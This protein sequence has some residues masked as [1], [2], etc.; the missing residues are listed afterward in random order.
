V[1]R[2]HVAA[3]AMQIAKRDRLRWTSILASRGDFVVAN[4][5]VFG[6]GLN[7]FVLNALVAI[8]RRQFVCTR[9]LE[10]C[11]G[12]GVIEEVKATYFVWT[13]VTAISSTDTAVVDHVV[14]SFM[15]VN[16]RSDRTNRFA[17]SILTVMTGHRL[18][19]DHLVIVLSRLF[20]VQ[21][22]TVVT[23]DANPVHLAT[24]ANIITS[25]NRHIVF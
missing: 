12:V 22:V 6:L 18:M 21:V 14:K 9:V 11:L 8:T 16:R 1:S 15:T 5:A 23:V 25:D 19:N 10:E 2:M 13:V 24:A 4:L 3:D 20:V 17:R 7:L